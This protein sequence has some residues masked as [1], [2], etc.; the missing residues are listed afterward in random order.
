M[1]KNP[2]IS[3]FDTRNFTFLI[4]KHGEFLPFCFVLRYTD[5][6]MIEKYLSFEYLITIPLLYRTSQFSS[7][8]SYEK[9]ILQSNSM[10][11]RNSNHTTILK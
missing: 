10:H 7:L 6:L 9:S 3:V 4:R 11:V 5:L 2:F 8:L 1:I